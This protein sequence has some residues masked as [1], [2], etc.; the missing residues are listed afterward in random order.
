[1]AQRRVWSAIHARRLFMCPACPICLHFAISLLGVCFKRNRPRPVVPV[2]GG[3]RCIH[4]L[5][6]GQALHGFTQ[7]A[8]RGSQ[9]LLRVLQAAMPQQR[10]NI[11]YISAA[12]KYDSR[13]TVPCTMPADI[14]VY[15]RPS[16]PLFQLLQTFTV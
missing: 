9:I 6:L 8:V 12:V 2:R 15:A 14:F 16:Y 7:K 10:G 13:K 5:Q 11:R 4:A 1:M 3:L